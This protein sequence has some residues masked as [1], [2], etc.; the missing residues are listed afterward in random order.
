MKTRNTIAILSALAM[1]SMAG[2]DDT[3][4]KVGAASAVPVVPPIVL[5]ANTDN[6]TGFPLLTANDIYTYMLWFTAGDERANC[7]QSTE[8]PL[9]TANDLQCFL[10]VWV[11]GVAIESAMNPGK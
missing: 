2:A 7:D 1:A 6:S 10:D 8:K 11:Q 3:A 4:S 5:Q 9:L